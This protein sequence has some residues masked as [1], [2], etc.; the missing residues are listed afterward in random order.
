MFVHK[1][2][3]DYHVHGLAGIS[4]V[5]RYLLE[6][7]FHHCV[8]SSRA[9]ILVVL[10][11]DGADF[12]YLLY[13]L[14]GKFEVDFVHSQ[15]RGVLHKNCVVGLGKDFF[16]ILFAQ[17]VKL[18]AYRET[19]LKLGNKVA[20]ARD[21][22]RAR[23]DKE[24]MVGVDLSVLGIDGTTLYDRQNIS[25]YALSRN[26]VSLS[27]VA[28]IGNLVDFVDE[29]YT[30]VFSSRDS[31][32]I[33]VVGVNEFFFFHFEK[34][35]R[36]LFDGQ[37]LLLY[38]TVVA[39]Y[40]RAENLVDIDFHIA[41]SDSLLL[42]LYGQCYVDN[43]IVEFAFSE[44]L[45]NIS[46]HLS[47]GHIGISFFSLLSDSG[48]ELFLYHFA[49]TQLDFLRLLFLDHSYRSLY[50]VSYH[51]L[52]V[53]SYITYFRKFRSF[54]FDERSLYEFCK[55]SCDFRFTYA[56]RSLHNNVLGSNFLSEC[57]RKFASSVSVAKSDRN[58]S[59]RAVLTD[60]VS[61]KFL[62]DLCGSKIV[63]ITP[64]LR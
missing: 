2:F 64:P 41:L 55:T 58:R 47:V 45:K 18:Y 40:H 56:R 28:L 35:F 4:R 1:L 25:L 36:C 33:Y 46:S 8:K 7:A 32:L 62:Y 61:V 54:Y 3:V 57:L 26:V 22:E 13:C 48:Y 16:K 5:K 30:L 23:R 34:I 19:S 53:S 9:Y 29:Y 39:A 37:C 31:L 20:Y 12:S 17:T 11:F 63:H 49:C 50:K 52:N 6:Q 15:K 24:N 10:V 51:R 59:F 42:R 60:N 44:F 43:Q 38:L 21:M 14:V 27:A